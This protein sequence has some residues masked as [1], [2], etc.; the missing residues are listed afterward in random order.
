MESSYE[1]IY[2]RWR[3]SCLVGRNNDVVGQATGSARLVAQILGFLYWFFCHCD[4][5]D[6]GL[7]RRKVYNSRRGVAHQHFNHSSSWKRI[8]GSRSLQQ[9]RNG[10]EGSRALTATRGRQKKPP[11]EKKP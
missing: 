2:R 10:F 11:I 8:W 3:N 7:L 4:I 5:G 9:R 6:D 1:P